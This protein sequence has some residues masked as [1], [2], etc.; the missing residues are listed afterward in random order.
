MPTLNTLDLSIIFVYFGVTLLVGLW[1]TR[2]ASSNLEEYYLGGRSLPWWL[3]GIAGMTSWFDLTGTMV[4]TSFLYMLGPRGLFI[5]FR[6]GAVLVLAFLLA[7]AGKWHRRSGCITFAEWMTYRFGEGKAAEGVRFVTAAMG[8]IMTIGMIAYL[9]RGCSLFVDMFLPWPPVTVTLVILGFSALYTGFSGFYGVVLT[10]LVQ[11]L[12]ILLSCFLVGFIAWDSITSTQEL[13]A[14]ALIATGNPEWTASLPSFKTAMPAG[15]EIYENLVMFALFYLLRNILGGMGSGAEPRYFGARNDRECGLQSF[16][17]GFMVMFRWPLMIGF[18][19]LGIQ[20]VVGLGSNSAAMQEAATVLRAE[21]PNITESNW[22][23]V[24]AGILNTTGLAT[25]PIAA[26][27]EA[28]L[29]VDWQKILPLIGYHGTV[30]PERILP[31]VLL[32]TI[33]SGL[34]GFLL[35]AMLA[36]L[37]STFTSTV[38]PASGLL[39]RDI[40]QNFLRPDA[41][42]RELIIASYIATF[43]I[44]GTGFLMGLAADSINNLWGWIVMGLGAGG[45][46]PALLRL[47]WW[48]C[49]A[50]GVLGG[51]IAGGAGAVIQRMLNPQMSEL[52]QFLLM[53][54][55]SFVATI[56]V[57]L[58]TPPT[59]MATLR[60]FYRT[61][62]PFGLWKPLRD[63]LDP[64]TRAANLKEHRADILTIPFAL[65]WQV[66]LFLIP[67][68]IIIKAY[69][70]ALATLPF[71]I[72]G[73]V[74]MYFFWWRN[75]GPKG[76]APV[77]N[78]EVDPPAVPENA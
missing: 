34:K 57:S 13:A 66:T 21:Y 3:L 9:V 48:R 39:V 55:I 22:H 71:L 52:H 53:T 33:P 64:V 77:T 67:M 51:T 44:A 37:M 46:A 72:V 70:S 10:D 65:L 73:S 58:F 11:G 8:V 17:Q 19:V 6:G 43:S 74:G 12:I 60:H 1:M 69:D 68:Q 31:A 30:N 25:L 36:A 28:T 24:T 45:L 26:Q 78:P 2:K 49:N 5:E 27:L 42:N 50:W 47:Y 41:G 38:N 62:R 20:L 54:T 15:Y 14:A 75:L 7:Y 4:I 76:P 56:G 32:F 16:L 40:Y 61:T 18:A 23:D 59:P 29:G 35:V 63:E